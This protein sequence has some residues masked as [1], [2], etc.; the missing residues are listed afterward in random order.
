ME[1]FFFI[2]IGFIAGARPFLE[3]F[4]VEFVKFPSDSAFQVFKGVKYSIT[5]LC[6]DRSGDLSNRSFYGDF[7][8][9]TPAGIIAVL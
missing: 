8:L 3:P 5:E 9:R 4:M 1:V 2:Q 6:D 7:G